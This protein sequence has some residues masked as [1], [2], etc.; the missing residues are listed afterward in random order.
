MDRISINIAGLTLA[1][2]ATACVVAAAVT[3][4]P[5]PSVPA[6][7][8]IETTVESQEGATTPSLPTSGVTPEVA[9]DYAVLRGKPDG[10]PASARSQISGHDGENADLARLVD[11]GSSQVRV[12]PKTRGVCVGVGSAQTCPPD[13]TLLEGR[14]VGVQY[15]TAPGTTTVWGLVPDGSKDVVVTTSDSARRPLPL[16]RN[17]YAGTVEGVPVL[18]SY[19]AGDGQVKSI[20]L[21]LPSDAVPS[22]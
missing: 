4:D 20:S 13:E 11:V 22:C 8:T 6:A 9:R 21:R 16:S 3:A 17:A 19:T 18:V 14:V 5:T 12:V 1:T 2:L 10:L 7:A 15:C